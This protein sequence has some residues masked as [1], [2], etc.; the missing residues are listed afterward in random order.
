MNTEP[1]VVTIRYEAQPG[2]R[3][4]ASTELR[5]LIR[6]VVAHEPDCLGITLHADAG[7][8]ARFLLY[9]RWTSQ[10]A[11]TGPHMKTPH[12]LA[13]I[14]KAGEFLAGPPSIEYWQRTDEVTQG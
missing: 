12:L 1:I 8:A 2:Q 6:E 13:F 10:A 5:A 3:E 11:Y 14:A 9:E 7:D 4:R